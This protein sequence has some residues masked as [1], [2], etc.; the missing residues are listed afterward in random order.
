M[1]SKK[2]RRGFFGLIAEGWEL[3]D[4]GS[5]WPRGR[6]PADA[7]P[8]EGIVGLLDLERYQGTRSPPADPGR[9]WRCT[10]GDPGWT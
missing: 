3:S 5:P 8:S 4:F 1:Q 6:I 10:R 9:G 7:E 2:H